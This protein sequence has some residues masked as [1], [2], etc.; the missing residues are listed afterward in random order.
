MSKWWKKGGVIGRGQSH[1]DDKT[2]GPISKW[3]C[4]EGNM[5]V[6]DS[7]SGVLK[8][9]GAGRTR[10]LQVRAGW[11]YLDCADL[12]LP[13]VMCSGFA[14]MML[15][16]HIPKRLRVGVDWP[17]MGIPLLDK[18]FWLAL[19]SDLEQLAANVKNKPLNVVACCQG[20]HGRTGSALSVIAGLYKLADNPVEFV[21]KKYC[22]KAVETTGQV[23]YVKDITELKFTAEPGKGVYTGLTSGI[24]DPVGYTPYSG[25]HITDDTPLHYYRKGVKVFGG[26]AHD[27]GTGSTN[28]KLTDATQWGVCTVCRGDAIDGTCVS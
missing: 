19:L 11:L 17:D 25:V 18:E 21:R 13:A 9:H 14:P 16:S 15:A 5:F 24:Y 6:F 23:N 27:E 3:K 22:D 4:H 2:H 26:G 12:Y 20:G 28:K 7:P 8:F 1:K 10:G